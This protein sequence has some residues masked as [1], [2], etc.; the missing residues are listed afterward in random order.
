MYDYSHIDYRVQ[1]IAEKTIKY[2]KR[3]LGKDYITS[4][5]FKAYE[6]AK[7]AHEGQMRL[8]GEPYILHP[9][10]AA[11]ILLDIKPDLAT[12]QACFLHDVIEDTPITYDD[13][14]HEF[15]IEVATI[16]AGMEKLGKVKYSGEQRAIESLRK[17]FVAMADDL[18]VIF[19]KLADRLHNMQTLH[20]H[21]KPEK[22]ERIATETLN[23][24]SPIAD[25]LGLYDLKHSL[26]EECFKI[27]YPDQYL[28]IT[29]Q[30]KEYEG[31]KAYF[32]KN[33]KREI[34]TILKDTGVKYKI[35]FRVKAI[36]SI[37]LKMQR[38]G[39]TDIHDIYDIYG[40][41]IIVSEIAACYKV[42][43]V[44]HNT[45]T[46]IPKQIKDYIALPKPN[47]YQSLHTTVI[48]LLKK[49]R[50]LPAEIQIK[51]K[52]MKKYS[53]LG[54]AA[55]FEYKEK[56]S[57]IATDIDWV[58]ELKDL[59]DSMGS[60][61]FIQ[62]LKIDVFK[63]RIFL[64]TPTGDTI[65]LPK[66]S[67]P[68]DFA[69]HIHTDIGNHAVLAKVNGSVFPLDK[70]LSNGDI[71]EIVVDKNKTPNP[72]WISF[73]KTLKAKN[74]IKAYLKKEN[75]EEN[76]ERGRDLVNKHL[77]RI[78]L[79]PLGKDM[80]FLK[81][82]D[83]RIHGTEE[84][85]NLLEQVGN[86]SITASTLIRRSLRA[87]KSKPDIRA[88][89]KHP[90]EFP[91]E[92]DTEIYEVGDDA[93]LPSIIIGGEKDLPFRI[94][95]CCID[96]LEKK[97]VA[98]INNKGVI[99]IHNRDCETLK[100]VN[101]DR[102]L[103]A[104]YEGE[105]EGVI[106]F[107]ITMILKNSVGIL[108]QITEILYL[109]NINIIHLETKKQKNGSMKLQM[110]LEL[111]DYDYLIIDRCIDRLKAKLKVSLQSVTVDRVDGD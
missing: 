55:H 58:K 105:N 98:H 71:V 92:N 110:G 56:G 51:T 101:S 26:D 76:I 23:I 102:L 57:K 24:Y 20:H 87:Q 109:M 68:I 17:M 29:N 32:K 97:I 2:M 61:D 18:R 35:D 5:I 3:T 83:G 43:G 21:P 90:S 77:E 91:D 48:G 1:Y 64:I 100:D 9:V 106:H 70:E 74:H 36:Y 82:M 66:G 50:K 111:G 38:K 81:Q 4:E 75:K 25:R 59:T 49:H 65:N 99:S 11:V 10:E 31:S 47:G 53:E 8:S 52:K 89:V 85:L 39:Y 84:R 107:D 34:D 46:P 62:S 86:F 104:Y 14:L 7:K 72:F 42:L 79:N 80:S 88:L 41:R 15:G 103:S 73:V 33:A 22:R 19:V 45:W 12:L 13:I 44:I 6:F 67:T 108:R 95:S 63:D 94:A 27:L 69:Y 54:M 28:N 30:L 37:F 40:I 60:S 16:C 78:G 93:Q 96:H